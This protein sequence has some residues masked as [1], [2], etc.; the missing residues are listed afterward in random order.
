M[1]NWEKQII[2]TFPHWIKK[3]K[4]HQDSQTCRHNFGS[5]F[6]LAQLLYKSALHKNMIRME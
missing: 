5:T 3:R 1:E 6:L 2:Q 4:V